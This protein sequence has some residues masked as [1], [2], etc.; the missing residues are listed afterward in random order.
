LDVYSCNHALP[1]IGKAE[2]ASTVE[3]LIYQ[4]AH[5]RG[6]SMMVLLLIGV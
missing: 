4:P 5:Q 1:F 3:R 6:N 2:L